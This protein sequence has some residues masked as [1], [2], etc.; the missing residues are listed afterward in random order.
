M[1]IFIMFWKLHSLW[2]LKDMTNNFRCEPKNKG[3]M[4]CFSKLTFKKQVSKK[5][6]K[7]VREEH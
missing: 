5:K 1:L 3:E 7:K 6:K 4:H 2:Q